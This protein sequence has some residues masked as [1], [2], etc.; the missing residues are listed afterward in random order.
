MLVELTT[1]AAAYGIY[2]VIFPS[3]SKQVKKLLS[4][5]FQEKK[6]YDI[7][8]N[9]PTI[10]QI[11]ITNY[12]AIATID[13]KGICSFQDLQK[14]QDFIKSLFGAIS[15]EINYKGEF[16]EIQLI[17]NK[18][19]DIEY[20]RIELNPF[21]LLLG[22]DLKG[23]PIIVD[24]LKTPHLLICGLSGSGKSAMI[25]GIIANLDTKVIMLNGFLDDYKDLNNIL[26]IQ[27]EEI[28]LKRLEGLLKNPYKREKPLYIFFEE[29]A[30]IKNKKIIQALKELLCIARHY[31]IFLIGLIQISTKEELACKSYFNARCSFRQIDSSSYSVALGVNVGD[32]LPKREFY[33]ISDDLYRGRTY[34]L[35]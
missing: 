14:Q 20:Q 5:L 19:Q 4:K 13:I 11:E 24:M 1:L 29:L 17:L 27:Q 2:K 16:I 8:G 26:H 32:P 34:L 12:G 33:V 30:T 28:I 23:I 35:T 9:Y 15:V 10:K 3:Q 21:E 18:L 25:R 7:K 6:F 31:N 22:H